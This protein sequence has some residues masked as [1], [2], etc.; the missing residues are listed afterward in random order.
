MKV[1]QVVR[2]SASLFKSIT[3]LKKSEFDRL[4]KQFELHLNFS[5][6]GRPHSLKEVEHALFF[7]LFYY[8]HYCTQQLMA[9]I[10]RVDQAQISRWIC[11]L[12]LPF[13]KCSKQ[14]IDKARERINSV[15]KLLEYN[16][17]LDVIID[18]TERPVLTHHNSKDLFSGKKNFCT[19]KNMV[20]VSR[21]TKEI[22]YS[23]R[24][25]TGARHD[26][27]RFKEFKEDI[28]PLWNLLL[29]L[30]FVGAKDEVPNRCFLP[31]KSLP[32]QSLSD[33]EI[34]QNR[35]LSKQRCRGEHPFGQMKQFKIL[36]DEFRGSSKL[37]DLSFQAIAGVYNFRRQSRMRSIS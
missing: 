36:S 19:V 8:R 33:Y 27:Y 35:V 17:D 12:Q 31:Y 22:T 30:G 15:E 29:D 2:K 24:T 26:F 9:L 37:C 3:G 32:K 1:Y 14:Y 21:K 28:P 23:S 4:A 34:Q 5:K 16:P 6:T 25:R 10:F 11:L 18:C 13:A 20:G 7:I